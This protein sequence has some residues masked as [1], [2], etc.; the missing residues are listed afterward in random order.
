M[1]LAGSCCDG[2]GGQG[3]INSVHE[4][5]YDDQC[6][7]CQAGVSWLRLLDRENQ[8]RAVALSD[9]V[10]PE[11]LEI[12]ECL[13]ELRVVTPNGLL[14]GWE[15]VMALARLFPATRL[16]GMIGAAPV[17]SWLGRRIYRWVAL[18]RYALSRCRGGRCRSARPVQVRARS[19][20]TAFW[21]CRTIGFGARAPLV[22]G[23]WA[24]GLWNNAVAHFRLFRRRVTLLDGRLTLLFLGSATAD[25]VPLFFGERFLAIVYEGVA[26]DPGSSKMR[27]WLRRHMDAWPERIHAVTTTHHHEEHSGN[28]QWL[29]ERAGA[30]LI[31]NQETIE[32]LR[33]LRLPRMR[34]FVI[35]QPPLLSGEVEILDGCLPTGTGGELQVIPTPGHCPDHVSFFDPKHKI[36]F[37]G[38]AFMGSYFATPNPD[39]DSLV[40]IESLERMLAL[41]VEI[42]VEGHGHIY[43]L[44][45][46][47]PDVAH[48]VIRQ[49]P[50]EALRNKLE[51]L[52]WVRDQIEEGKRE[53]MPAAAIVGSC[54]PWG[55]R[56]SWERF[57]SELTAQLLSGGE[58][59]RAELVRSFQR[60]SGDAVLPVVYEISR[61]SGRKGPC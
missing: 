5:Y 49:C 47:I 9:A 22:V 43:T 12:E 48:V 15:A 28:L 52:C 7:I 34:R 25:M 16:I 50:R 19:T 32:R 42:L 36:L 56:W 57:G 27:D 46:D 3:R 13:R 31:V 26:I 1:M 14:T 37:A 54:F 39:V 45:E 59:S 53:G 11:G 33:T 2:R 41:E 18:H 55:R 17:F 30:R 6:E 4:V 61:I 51:F 23:A 24:S 35:G 60:P 20:M 40:W 44:R 10:L 38:D 29:A 8:V 21:S 58:F